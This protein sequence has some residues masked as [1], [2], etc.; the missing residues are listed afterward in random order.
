MVETTYVIG[1]GFDL[2]L[3]LKTSYKDFYEYLDEQINEG[4][5]EDNGLIKDIEDSIKDIRFHGDPN[6]PEKLDPEKERPLVNWAN[7]EA[8]IKEDLQRLAQSEITHEVLSTRIDDFFYELSKCLSQYL[9]SQNDLVHLNVS[10]SQATEGI[11]A[12]FRNLASGDRDDL[13]NSIIKGNSEITDP[14]I[15]GHFEINFV[16]FN[17]TNT[18]DQYVSQVANIDDSDF[19]RVT[20]GSKIAAVNK[21]ILH[22]NGTF[23]ET[24][25]VGVGRAEDIPKELSLE[26]YQIDYLSKLN[27]ARNRHDGRVDET[28][29]RLKDS[30]VTII[31]GMSIGE[32]DAV[33]FD[34]II[35]GM[36]ANPHKHV[37]IVRLPA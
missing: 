33:Y 34:K 25:I 22:P 5:F 11:L 30:D 19:K 21:K 20:Y 1:N 24:S 27:F 3:G 23:D 10:G 4:K 17:Y 37:I 14:N 12:P 28:F 16:N 9:H 8:G 29:K 15:K 32:S 6:K 7:L 13:F 26:D 18:L 31:Y 36:I 35:E 2:H